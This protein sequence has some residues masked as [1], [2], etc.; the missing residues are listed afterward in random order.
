VEPRC[1]S[2]PRCRGPRASPSTRR[3]VHGRRR[4]PGRLL[5]RRAVGPIRDGLSALD[6]GALRRAQGLAAGVSPHARRWRPAPHA[7]ASPPRPAGSHRSRRVRISRITLGGDLADHAG[8]G[9]RGSRWAGISAK[10][11]QKFV[12]RSKRFLEVGGRGIEAEV[13]E[14]TEALKSVRNPVTQKNI[15]VC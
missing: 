11:D 13:V 14:M 3:A 10:P 5:G 1:G 8:R 2:T 4:R 7:R 9:S 12:D 6:V 15:G